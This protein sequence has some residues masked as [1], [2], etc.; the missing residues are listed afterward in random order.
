MENQL[1]ENKDRSLA[2]CAFVLFGAT[3]DLTKRK[4]M[5]GLFSLF[6][7]NL[8]PQNFVIVAFARRDKTDEQFREELKV[9]MKEFAPK[10]PSDGEVWDRF[11]NIV[12]YV[13]SSFDEPEG[14]HRLATRLTELDT[15]FNLGGNHLFYLA[16]P[17][18]NFSEIIANLGVAGLNNPRRESGWS[19]LIIEKPFGIDLNTAIQLNTELNS[20]FQENQVY[21]IDHYLGKEAVQNI[22]VLR[23]ANQ[24]FEPLWNQ[25][26]I[27]NVQ[28]TVAETL[29]VEGRGGYFESSGI[30]RDIVQNHAIQVLTL[31]A[32]EPPASLSAD[33]VRGEKVKVL[34]SIRPFTPEEVALWTVRGQY[35]PNKVGDKDLPGYR[36]EEGVNP[37]SETE[38]FAAFKFQINNWRWAGVPFYVQAGKRMPARLTEVKIQFKS[39]PDVLFRK[40]P[41]IQITPN[42]LTLRIQPDE[43]ASIE[44]GCKVPGPEMSVKPVR[45][46]FLYGAEFDAPIRDAYERL[47]L[48]AIRGD[49]SLFARN[50]EVEEAWRIITPIMEAWRDLTCPI[51]PN[52]PAG[53][54]GPRSAADLLSDGRAWNLPDPRNFAP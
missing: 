11:A 23:F 44:V 21:R 3:G 1:S 46:N 39:P 10:L 22:L 18:D 4:I 53:T 33:D 14:Y 26:Y 19:R 43:G 40:M 42:I 30:T 45:M 28:I 6:S 50:D 35:G 16:T 48:D 20:V 54:W 41:N 27:D 25:K 51:F 2:S 36:Q 29:G 24:I 31:I 13:R 5:P 32:M 7:Q 47:I 52:Y 12:F 17:P 49:A 38:T 34:K 15:Q 8:L 9:N 37:R